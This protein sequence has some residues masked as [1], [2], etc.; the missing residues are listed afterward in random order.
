MKIDRAF[1]KIVKKLDQSLA[2]PYFYSF[3]MSK[4]E[5]KM[6]DKYISKSNNYLEFGMGGSTIRTLLKSDAN[7]SSLD[8]STVWLDMMREYR[9]IRNNEGKRLT[10]FHENIGQTGSWGFPTS[11]DSK[12][13]F[14]N[15]SSSIF[16]KMNA[17]IIDTTL[18]DG[19]FRV[20]C[21]LKTI[22][23]CYSNKNLRI[24][25]HDFWNR[26]K[27]HIVLQY[28]DVLDKTDTLGVFSIKKDVALDSVEKDY[29]KYK[30]IVG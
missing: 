8:S 21:T 28:L 6:F 24:L 15:Y 27:Y 25:I 11:E 12:D 17:R 13:L 20:A 2:H 4:E 5:K 22:L 14:P 9:I 26:E 3:I 1:K 23:E 19:R 16:D 29:E 18:I 10:L 30:F 7:I